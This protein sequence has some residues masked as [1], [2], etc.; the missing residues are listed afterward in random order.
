MAG[1]GDRTR[2]HDK[3]RYDKGYD[4]VFG[5]KPNPAIAPEEERCPKCGKLFCIC[6]LEGQ[7]DPLNRLP[8]LMGNAAAECVMAVIRGKDDGLG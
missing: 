5:E 2:P 3:A 6:V 7:D 1:K 4:D 8:R